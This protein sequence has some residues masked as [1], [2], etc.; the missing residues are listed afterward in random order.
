MINPVLNTVM[1]RAAETPNTG[2]AD[3]AALIAAYD[4][5]VS[6]LNEGVGAIFA[7]PCGHARQHSWRCECRGGASPSTSSNAQ[8]IRV[9]ADCQ[10]VS[11]YFMAGGAGNAHGGGFEP[12]FSPD[13]RH[14]NYLDRPPKA[15]AGPGETSKLLRM[16]A[17]A[18]TQP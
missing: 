1:L 15:N 10:P 11:I 17:A 12:R 2:M 16:P 8:S 13:S 18:G 14:L 9:S 3:P 6:S 4:R 7:D 5:F